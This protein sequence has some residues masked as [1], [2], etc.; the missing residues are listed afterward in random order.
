ME[1]VRRDGWWV[2]GT[3]ER[4]LFTEWARFGREAD[5]C[6]RLFAEVWCSGVVSMGRGDVPPHVV[7][8]HRDAVR[9]A[10]AEVSALLDDGPVD[11][12]DPV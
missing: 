4:G 5:A 1:L 8:A 9:A 11:G 6:R 2:I 12:R 3:T 7:T 10:V